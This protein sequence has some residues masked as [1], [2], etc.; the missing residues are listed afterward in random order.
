[1]EY[2]KDRMIRLFVTLLISALICLFSMTFFSSDGIMLVEVLLGMLLG[3][4]IWGVS[5]FLTDFIE[6]KWPH[7]IL[8]MYL[9]MSIVIL[10]GTYIATFLLSVESVWHRVI[11]C[12][13]AEIVGL[14][15]M[16]CSRHIYKVQLNN[17]LKKYKGREEN[18]I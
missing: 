13:V 3:A 9:V 10:T 1:M 16:V 15:I 12:L 4:C 5:E 6:K 14:F 18:E 8:P 17:M 2:F 11:I 7:K